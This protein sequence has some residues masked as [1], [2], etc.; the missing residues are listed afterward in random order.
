[1]RSGEMKFRLGQAVRLGGVKLTAL[2][3]LLDQRRSQGIVV[4][5][6]E[7]WVLAGHVC[8]PFVT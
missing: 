6:N 7:N 4:V 5:H 1:M 2:D 8:L 3:K